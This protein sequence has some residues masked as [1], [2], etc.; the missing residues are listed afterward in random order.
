MLARETHILQQNQ[1]QPTEKMQKVCLFDLL[2]QLLKQI[3]IE[4][5]L[6]RDPQ[7]IA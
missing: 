6:N 7:A 4:K 3:G 5:L 2:F 1:V